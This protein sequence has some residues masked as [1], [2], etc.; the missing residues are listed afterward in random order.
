[1]TTRFFLSIVLAMICSVTFAEDKTVTHVDA[2]AAE[3]LV[4]EGKV[5][6]VDVRSPDEYKEDHIAGA[7]NVDFF[8]EDFAKELDK[9]DKSKPYLIH[10]ASG[11]RSTSSLKTFEKLGFKNLFHLDG[12][13]NA[14]KEAGKPV[15]K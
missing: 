10:C 12:G 6:V 5:T 15:E 3:K 7:K 11:K 1:M 14:W 9:L 8:A 13:F 4:K 2:N